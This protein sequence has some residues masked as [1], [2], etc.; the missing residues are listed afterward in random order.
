MKELPS[1]EEL[2]AKNQGREE[3]EN[4]TTCALAGFRRRGA[5]EEG[6][7]KGKYF[8][9]RLISPFLCTRQSLGM[10]LRGKRNGGRREDGVERKV[11]NVGG[12]LY[13]NILLT[14][15]H[16]T[17]N[18]TLKAQIEKMKA[19]HQQSE[20]ILKSNLQQVCGNTHTHTHNA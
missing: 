18:A 9:P 14:S 5:R 15:V 6:E 10:R 11:S 17:E 7:R 8:A 16:Q 3:P 20:D 13:P 2:G 4:K 12:L 1:A 19:E